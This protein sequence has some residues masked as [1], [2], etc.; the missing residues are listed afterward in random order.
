MEAARIARRTLQRVASVAPE[1]Q[2]LVNADALWRDYVGNPYA[3]DRTYLNREFAVELRPFQIVR[4]PDGLPT[5][6]YRA[7][8]ELRIHA[9]VLESEIETIAALV[10]EIDSAVVIRG[11]CEGYAEGVVRMTCCTIVDPA[12]VVDAA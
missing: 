5:F 2:V 6:A 11:T 10:K 9:F 8:G 12:S 4:L 3:A 1:P 7:W